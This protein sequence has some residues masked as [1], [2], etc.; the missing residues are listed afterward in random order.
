MFDEIRAVVEAHP[1]ILYALVFGSGARGTLHEGSDIDV[2]IEL[3]PGAPHD[4]HT[5]RRLTRELEAAARRAVDLVLLDEA[6]SPIAYRVFRDGILLIERDHEALT[7]RKAR[8]IV[9]YLDFQ[10]VEEL[11]AAGVLRAARGR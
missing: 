4:A 11:C 10:P 8:A 2:A 6:P 1:D 9:E 7:S 3:R 5:L